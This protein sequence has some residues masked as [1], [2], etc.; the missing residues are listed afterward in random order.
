MELNKECE[1]CRRELNL[2]ALF[3]SLFLTLVKGVVGILG[4]SESL[5][6]DGLYSFYQSF[7]ALRVIYLG[8]Y[9]SIWLAG[10]VVCLMLVLGIGDVLLFSVIRIAKA[11]KGLLVRPSPYALYAAILSIMAN[12]VLYR[13]SLCAVKEGQEEN[14]SGAEISQSLRISVIISSVVVIGIAIARTL[15]IYGDA[16]AALVVTTI[17]I[18]KLFRFFRR[19]LKS[20]TTWGLSGF[21]AL[22]GTGGPR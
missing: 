9:K 12:Q 19:N 21:K 22:Q 10:V 13:Y 2:W 17:V 3:V 8:E 6:A 18:A 14:G 1:R 20:G 11:A 15:S 16:L 5:V 4:S 7:V